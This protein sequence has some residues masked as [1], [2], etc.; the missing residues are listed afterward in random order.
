[1]P[2]RKVIT[3]LEEKINDAVAERYTDFITGMQRGV[4]IWAAEI[5]LRLRETNSDI[6][7]V[8][9]SAFEGMENGWESGW[10]RRYDRII[11]AADEVYFISDRPGRR[12]FFE[13]NEWMVDYSSRLIAVYNGA[14]GGTQKTID[15]AKKLR[16]DIVAFEK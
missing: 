9:A 8:A 6:V 12:A 16:R 7:L 11:D 2:E 3:W 14:P 10:K 5:V 4:D 13:R 15:Y 1:M